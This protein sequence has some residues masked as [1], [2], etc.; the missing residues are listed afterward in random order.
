M[1]T[2]TLLVLPIVTIVALIVLLK[3]VT[4]PGLYCHSGL[5]HV[6]L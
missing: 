6:G 4:L 3:T 1:L 2:H 5:F